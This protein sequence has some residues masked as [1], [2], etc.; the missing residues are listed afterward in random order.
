LLPPRTLPGAIVLIVGGAVALDYRG[1]AERVPRTKRP[2]GFRW[3]T[4]VLET[5][6]LFGGFAVIGAVMLMVGL[7]GEPGG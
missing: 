3:E 6:L 4:S 5:R 2:F 7:F 1:L